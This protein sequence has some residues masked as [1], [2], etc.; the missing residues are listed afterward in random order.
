MKK[1]V[2]TAAFIM[3]AS[4]IFAQNENAAGQ[5]GA[6]VKIHKVALGETVILI[7]KKYM[8]TPKDIYELNPDAV[9][10][11]SANQ[12]IKIPIDKSVPISE[13]EQQK[14]PVI[15]RTAAKKGDGASN[16]GPAG[17][18]AS[19]NIAA[20][21]VQ[22]K[23]EQSN[24]GPV[25]VKDQPITTGNAA[26]TDATPALLP[27]THLVKGGETL[28]GLARKYN[29]TVARIT[30]EN[31]RTLKRGLQTGQKLNIT[32]GP[33]ATEIPQGPAIAES[34]PTVATEAK[35]TDAAYTSGGSVE[36]HVSAGETLHGLA[37]RYH[38]T[39]EAI[40]SQNKKTLRHGLQAGQTLLIS[41]GMVSQ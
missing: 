8:V 34:A 5:E 27:M 32:P 25:A 13:P 4:S 6:R 23:P 21:A 31:S 29:T 28:T 10:G 11:I 17:E 14:I 37:R 40:S 39:V 15:S 41:A 22:Q 16:N 24:T 36:H 1:I 7:A 9:N 3:L 18:V 38:T 33:T 2:M 12:S 30:E 35:L 19:A 26:V 20:P